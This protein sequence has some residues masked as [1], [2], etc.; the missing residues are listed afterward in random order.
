M[1]A[2]H[3]AN[4][5]LNT[6]FEN[7]PNGLAVLSVV[8]LTFQTANHA[9]QQLT[10]APHLNV[11]G[12]RFDEVWP[13]TETSLFVE[14]VQQV[15]EQNQPVDIDRIDMQFPVATQRSFSLRV[16]PWEWAGEPAVLLIMREMQPAPPVTPPNPGPA[17]GGDAPSSGL[18]LAQARLAAVLEQDQQGVLIADEHGRL[19]QANQAA[20][21]M[22]GRPLP[23]HKDVPA[24]A[25]LHICYPDGHPY[26][27][28]SLPMVAAAL[29]GQHRR[30]EEILVLLPDNGQRHLLIS[31]APINDSQGS[32]IGA[33]AIMQDITLR[34][35][36]SSEIRTQAGRSQLLASLS[37]AFAEAGLNHSELLETIARAIG[38]ISGDMCLIQLVDDEGRWM[39]MA[40]FSHPDSSVQNETWP[41]MQ[42][43]H[44][45]VDAGRLGRVC[46]AGQVLR[47]VEAT[48]GDL[49]NTFPDQCLPAMERL[50]VQNA[51][52]VPLR[53]RGRWVG[54]LGIMRSK[55]EHF[56]M[57]DQ[58]FYQ[59]LADRAALALEDARL[60]EQEAVR[61][62]ELS[63]LH[64]A[65]TALL[66]TIDLETLLV[67]I[68]DA[69]Q[70]AIPVAKQGVL[71]LLA[72]DTGSLVV[73]AQ[74]S[75]QDPRIQK[76]SAQQI[77]G[78]AAQAVGEKRAILMNEIPV[79]QAASSKS[80][81]QAPVM[82]SAI[83]APLM[84]GNHVQGALLL[85]SSLPNQFHESD[86]RLLDSFAA[87]ATAALHNANL[88]SEV[89]RL[90]TTDTLTELYNRRRFFELG[91]MEM[92][93][94]RR[95]RRPLSAIML[96]LDNFKAIND[97]YGHDAGDIVLFT[98]ASRI[99]NSIRVIDILG[100]YGGDEFAI[101]L[102]S[103]STEEA[104]VI[105]ERIRMAIQASPIYSGAHAIHMAISLGIAQAIDVNDTLSELVKRADS[106]LLQAKQNGRNQVVE[107][108]P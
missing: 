33:V 67:E 42:A 47:L 52:F 35:R 18:C 26:A 24:L 43:V 54:N 55:R 92:H 74:R 80:S 58:F 27:P 15:L 79:E 1:Q 71:Y 56:T 90:A 104:H 102:P 20:E 87:T 7:D 13:G 95:F 9:Y 23:L 99:R 101:L 38:S 31:S 82:A 30:D 86:L 85:A 59:D 66:S 65:T 60:Y 10:P 81:R 29:D 12:R 73:R 34:K 91:E 98:V 57:E 78:L 83:I 94:F 17:A 39:R 75:F 8:D 105:A 89:Q 48:P 93:R 61:L 14:Q 76:V 96:D 22:L 63:A 16:C 44:W 97:T 64:Q 62:R 32:R 11:A 4:I 36:A 45:P 37:Q 84:L 28:R 68:I 69:A 53:A 70:R 5:L 6:L 19:V 88:Y 103:A 51:L 3:Q 108:R 107:Y 21:R 25:G 100:R 41:P 50:G 106:A 46:Q 77:Q 2:H 40:A 49:R 72:P